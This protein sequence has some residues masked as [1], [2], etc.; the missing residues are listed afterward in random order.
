VC[1]QQGFAWIGLGT[2]TRDGRA[3]AFCVGLTWPT[4]AAPPHWS[5]P[6]SGPDLQLLDNPSTRAQWETAVTF[7]ISIPP[8]I[9]SSIN[10]SSSL[11]SPSRSRR[12]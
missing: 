3:A 10:P 2:A 6:F 9:M 11:N 12:N 7:G 8:A 5:L 1:S 4:M